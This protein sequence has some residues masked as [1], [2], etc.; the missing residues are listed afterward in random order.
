MA[1]KASRLRPRMASAAVPL[2]KGAAAPL[3]RVAGERAG[4]VMAV[5]G[6]ML[7]AALALQATGEGAGAGAE[8]PTRWRS[9]ASTR[10]WSR[11]TPR[12]RPAAALWPPSGWAHA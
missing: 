5:A 12:C 11:P 7:A 8:G 2:A 4:A 10:S 3:D 6:L 9:A 1:R